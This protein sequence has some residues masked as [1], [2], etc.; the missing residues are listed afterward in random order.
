MCWETV[1]YY[2]SR[3]KALLELLLDKQFGE[4]ARRKQQCEV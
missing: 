4:E 2:R 1:W 3:L